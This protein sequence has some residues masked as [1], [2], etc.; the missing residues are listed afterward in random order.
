MKLMADSTCDLSQDVI[1]NYDISIIPLTVTI[2]GTDYK[3]RLDITTDSYFKKLEAGSE[4]A[5]TGAPSPTLYVDHFNKAIAEGHR[6][7][8]CI[9]MS[10]GT[11]ASYQSGELGKSQF[12]EENPNADVEIHIVD[13]KS[14]SHGSGW[15]LMKSAELA[16]EGQSFEEIVAFV[17]SHKTKVKHFLS[18][19]DLSHLIRSGR[20][21]GASALIG[22]FLNIK[23]IMS[24]K[25]GKGAVVAKE[26][27]RNRVLKHYVEEFSK[28]VDSKNTTFLIIGYSTE[29]QVALDLQKKLQAETSFSGD[30]HIMQMGVA[31]AT[32]VGP[33]GLSMFFMEN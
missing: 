5:S 14:M 22:K 1:T 30:I 8:L 19:D 7:I 25:A 6:E 20:I 24:M 4:S 10:S 28:R 26:R 12:I 16:K 18:V 15:L 2:E 21:S 17:E 27:G 32:H 23:P 9:C 11:S 33:G 3:D 29:R 31:V 13:S